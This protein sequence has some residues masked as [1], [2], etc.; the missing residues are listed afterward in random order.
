MKCCEASAV[1]AH[2]Q[3]FGLTETS[4]LTHCHRRRSVRSQRGRG[5]SAQTASPEWTGSSAST[6]PARH[7]IHVLAN[8]IHLELCLQILDADFIVDSSMTS[9]EAYIS[10]L[11]FGEKRQTAEVTICIIS[12][13]LLDRPWT[14]TARL[15]LGT[16]N[17]SK[18]TGP[19]AE[20]IVV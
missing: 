6:A 16:R 3:A 11:R 4:L 12:E 15:A 18:D 19:E 8:E 1:V 2:R 17:A 7:N 5:L 14:V 9:I 20:T 10:Q 13:R